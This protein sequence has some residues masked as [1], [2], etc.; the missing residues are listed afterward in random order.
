M[1]TVGKEIKRIVEGEEGQSRRGKGRRRSW[2]E[3]G[4][5]KGKGDGQ[6]GRIE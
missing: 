4:G 2:R 3:G 6:A 1:R 5:H